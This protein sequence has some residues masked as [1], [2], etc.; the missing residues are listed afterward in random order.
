MLKFK[1]NF[2]YVTLVAELLVL[3][4]YLAVLACIFR[5]VACNL[6]VIVLCLDD[7]LNSYIIYTNTQSVNNIP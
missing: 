7:E 4:I 3:F 6:H 2:V 1:A 5:F